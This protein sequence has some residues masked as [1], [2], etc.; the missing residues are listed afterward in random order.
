ML[1]A[2]HKLFH[3]KGFDATS[4]REISVEAGVSESMLFRHFGSKQAIF[5]EAVLQPFA[6]FV[7]EFVTDWMSDRRRGPE[8]IAHSYVSGL[9]ALCRNHLD[10]ITT[11][12]ST[13]T[14]GDDAQPGADARLLIYE[15]LE[16]LA[17]HVGRY[18]VEAGSRPGLD[19]RLS[20]RL[21]IALVVGAAQLGEDFFGIGD[22][23]TTELADFVVRGAGTERA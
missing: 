14:R 13:K 22:R 23:L 15:Q 6:D 18:H 2:A 10:L 9:F 8:R 5:E 3:S 16:I 21:A 1:G 20:V 7:E 4:T 11:L 17:D 19:P 12:S